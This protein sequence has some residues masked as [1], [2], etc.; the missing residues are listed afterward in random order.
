RDLDQPLLGQADVRVVDIR[1]IERKVRIEPTLAEGELGAVP[2]ELVTDRDALLV[3]VRWR[4]QYRIY[5]HQTR[6]GRFGHIG[7][8]PTIPRSAKEQPVRANR[9]E[10]A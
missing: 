8:I 4:E 9:V 7:S 5:R 3:D 2:G 6:E 10:R 1:H